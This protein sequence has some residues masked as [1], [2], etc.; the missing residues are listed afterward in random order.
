MDGWIRP[1]S[2][3]EPGKVGGRGSHPTHNARQQQAPERQQRTHTLHGK[4]QRRGVDAATVTG[5]ILGSQCVMC[6]KEKE[7]K[8]RERR[9]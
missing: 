6:T 5:G 7:R 8:E 9:G 1:A 3:C 2:I 4:Q